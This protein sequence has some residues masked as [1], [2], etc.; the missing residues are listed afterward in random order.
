MIKDTS[1]Q[2]IAVVDQGVPNPAPKTVRNVTPRSA[3]FGL[4]L[5]LLMCAIMPYNDYFVGATFLSGNYFPIVGVAAIFL[6]TMMINPMLIALKRRHST[7]TSAE[8]ITVWSMIVVVAGIPSSG[9]MRYLVPH[10]VAPLY[11]QTPANGWNK[12][13]IQHIPSRLIVSDPEAVRE[14][15]EGLKPGHS[16]PWGAW[17]E[18]M[19][20]W[21]VFAGLLYTIFFSF[22]TIV[23]HHWVE[24][25]RLTFPLVRLPILLSESPE[26]GRSLPPILRSPFLWFAVALVTVLHTV[27]GLHMFYPAIPVA[28]TPIYSSNYLTVPPLNALNG[29]EIAVYPLIIGFAYLLSTEVCFSLWFFYLFFK[30]EVLIAAMNSWDI[31]SYGSGINMGPDFA[32]YQEAGGVCMMAVWLLWSMRMHL[33]KAW[34][35]AIGRGGFDDSNEAMGYSS[36]FLG[37]AIGYV[38]L[39]VWMTVVARVQ[40]LMAFGVLA[41]SAFMFVVLAWLVAQ[42]GLLFVQFSFAPSQITADLN[43]GGGFNVQ[44]LFM[45]NM[46]EH[47]GW[48]D[49]REIMLPTVLNAQMAA[50]TVH[51]SQRS[52]RKALIGAVALA[53]I[54]SA[55]SSIWLPYTHGGASA[56]S[57]GWGYISAPQV[58]FNWAASRVHTIGSHGASIPVNAGIGAVVVLAIM[59]IRNGISWL[60]IHPAGF[61]VAATYPM[62]VMWFS[63]FVG[64]A[65][66]SPILR[67]SGLRGYRNFLPFFI[68]LILGDCLN[69]MVWTGIGLIT[70]TGYRLLP[71]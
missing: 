29:I 49:S 36:A 28:L 53:F 70:H 22:S 47:I 61:L 34:L 63:L 24:N 31:S 18:P 17:L 52:L 25:E 14:F 41:G 26:V 10:I 55:V 1:K 43:P 35:R 54:V 65:L 13:I 44:S 23:R 58:P 59:L 60:P 30:A 3:A 32:A 5:G 71:G 21:A 48:Y 69:A 2:A 66:K 19:A 38:G 15:Y 40:V 4:I 50:G 37:L 16:I 33:K 20:W 56:L 9:M 39:F 62:S 8:I 68:G 45:G 42:A 6:I 67:Y 51:L 27:N 64:W 7:F 57:D 11:F 12:E 46:T